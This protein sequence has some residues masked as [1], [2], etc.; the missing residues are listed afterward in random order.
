MDRQ[1]PQQ[2]PHGPFQPCDRRLS[3]ILQQAR[4]GRVS[5]GGVSL[6][7]QEMGLTHRQPAEMAGT[8]RVSVTLSLIPLRQLG[9]LIRERDQLVLHGSASCLWRT[10][11]LH[12]P[13]TSS[14]GLARKA[15]QVPEACF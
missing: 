2:L 7:L 13:S 6:A 8:R 14:T 4:F 12:D 9:T 11:D 3:L 1:A 10:A 5:R 15:T